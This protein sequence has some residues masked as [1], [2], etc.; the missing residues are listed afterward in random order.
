MRKR[1]TVALFMAGLLIL[2]GCQRQMP[3]TEP[4]NTTQL[5]TYP[6]KPAATTETMGSIPSEDL[7]QK[8]ETVAT[9]A[10]DTPCTETTVPPNKQEGEIPTEPEKPKATKPVPTERGTEP[11]DQATVPAITEPTQPENEP[12]VPETTEPET[13]PT[14]PV[15]TPTE[16]RLPEPTECSHE[17]KVI[18]HEEKG[19]WRAGLICNCGWTV[20]GKVDEVVAKWNA[21]SASYSVKEALL[22]HGG[23]SSVDEWIVDHSAYDESVCCHCGK[24]KS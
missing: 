15:T 17:W 23:Y 1:K 10:M 19:H 18:H 20:Y 11:T 6:A 5:S 24:R 13:K 22:E 12:T 21:H 2:S 9:T 14:V 8:E 16:P 4:E 7:L 3:S